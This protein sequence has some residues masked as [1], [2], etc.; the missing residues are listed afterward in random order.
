MNKCLGLTYNGVLFLG[1]S[2]LDLYYGVSLGKKVK[3][4]E[5]KSNQIFLEH[6]HP[7]F[8]G[9]TMLHAYSENTRMLEL[10]LE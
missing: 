2:L 8:E 9:K 4:L 5:L 10:L 3:D 7:R 1:Y 6:F